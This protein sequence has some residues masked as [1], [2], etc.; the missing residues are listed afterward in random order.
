MK[1]LIIIALFMCLYFS[2]ELYSQYQKFYDIYTPKGSIVES[3]LYRE[4][5]KT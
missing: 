1:K 5:G 2:C 4:Y 3:W